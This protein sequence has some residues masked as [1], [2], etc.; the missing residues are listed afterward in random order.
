MQCKNLHPLVSTQPQLRRWQPWLLAGCFLSTSVAGLQ[1]ADPLA[2]SAARSHPITDAIGIQFLTSQPM[3]LLGQ[4]KQKSDQAGSG[5]NFRIH[6]EAVVDRNAQS[7]RPAAAPVPLAPPRSLNI[8]PPSIPAA[9]PS[10]L[11]TPPTPIALSETNGAEDRSADSLQQRQP[12]RYRPKAMV[13]SV[14][15][16][17]PSSGKTE[18]SDGKDNTRAVRT[19]EVA[20][21]PT[22]STRAPLMV[23]DAEQLQQSLDRVATD[24]APIV[25]T[26]LATEDPLMKALRQ[27]A[28]S[29]TEPP[30]TPRSTSSAIQTPSFPARGSKESLP[31]AETGRSVPELAKLEPVAAP[32]GLLIDSGKK[33]EAGATSSGIELSEAAAEPEIEWNKYPAA[34]QTLRLAPREVRNLR[35]N[36]PV[37][38]VEMVR[39]NKVQAV[40][41]SPMDLT[42][43]GVQ[44]GTTLIVFHPVDPQAAPWSL[45]FQVG[46][47]GFAS[48]SSTTD[49]ELVQQSIQACYPNSEVK[50]RQ[51]EQGELVVEGTV[52]SESVARDI[53]SMVRQLCLVPIQ[54]EIVSQSK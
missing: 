16:K 1:G 27:V 35:L 44:E 4:P 31:P 23:A 48:G 26:P 11:P 28:G 15:S 3:S 14:E 24:T 12:E 45:A 17:G 52:P 7:M 10:S 37:A 46:R 47:P 54:D 2:S 38:R 49:L 43:L 53:L 22:P 8:A 39:K 34:L 20:A 30:A 50:L 13:V 6:D 41:R 32:A 36:R 21:V 18:S 40:L 33:A 25:A 9:A 5:I 19:P 42:L 51:G 29:Y